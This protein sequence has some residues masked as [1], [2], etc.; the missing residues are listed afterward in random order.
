MVVVMTK[1][2]RQPRRG[3]ALCTQVDSLSKQLQGDDAVPFSSGRGETAENGG[4][5]LSVTAEL[6]WTESQRELHPVVVV[7]AQLLLTR[8]S[9][10]AK[11]FLADLTNLQP[12]AHIPLP[13]APSVGGSTTVLV[14]GKSLIIA[15]L[16]SCR[17]AN[18]KIIERH[19]TP[20]AALA[21]IHHL[22]MLRVDMTAHLAPSRHKVSHWRAER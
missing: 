21:Y 2:T 3:Q 12:W 15:A 20:E 22:Q 7:T 16:P 18:T 4:E 5:A 14:A 17:P 9:Q 13:P 10:S 11:T 8:T 1:N 19:V 6:R